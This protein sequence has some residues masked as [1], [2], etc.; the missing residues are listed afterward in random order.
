MASMSPKESQYRD[1]RTYEEVRDVLPA[2]DNDDVIPQARATLAFRGEA[3]VR[4][5]AR[6]VDDAGTTFTV[7]LGDLRNESNEWAIHGGAG[8]HYVADGLHQHSNAPEWVQQWDGPFTVSVDSI[9]VIEG[10]HAEY[11]GSNLWVDVTALQDDIILKDSEGDVNLGVADVW[12]GR[13]N[14]EMVIILDPE[15]SRLV[16]F[17][18]EPAEVQ[19]PEKERST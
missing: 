19:D 10:D 13:E 6:A 18:I 4:G 7:P 8:L 1:T 5:R 3:W 9:D 14:E 12:V 15:T 16:E 17:N 11:R 2:P